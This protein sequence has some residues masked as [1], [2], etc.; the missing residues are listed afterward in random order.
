MD[1]DRVVTIKDFQGINIRIPHTIRNCSL[2]AFDYLVDEAVKNTLIISSPGCGKTT[3][4]R[5]VVDGANY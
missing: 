5:E 2:M 1:G 4:L 3:F